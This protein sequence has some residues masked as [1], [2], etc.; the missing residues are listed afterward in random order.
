MKQT[1]QLKLSQH[2]T[3]TPQLQ[4][5]IRLLQLSTTELNQELEKF[6]TENPLLERE[7]AE[8]EPA[9]A[10]LNG[11]SVST[12]QAPA[13]ES[14]AENPSPAD[15]FSADIDWSGGSGPSVGSRDDAD[16]GDF[17]Q[18]PADSPSLRE[19]LLRQLSL[20]QL[21]QTDRNLVAFLIEALNDDGYL[22]QPLEAGAPPARGAADP[23]RA[24]DRAQ[25]PAELRPDG[26]GARSCAEHLSFSCC[27]ANDRGRGTACR[28]RAPRAAAPRFR[29]LAKLH[30]EDGCGRRQHPRAHRV[31]ARNQRRDALIV[32]TPPLS[33]K[34][35][36]CSRCR[37][38]RINRMY[39]EIEQPEPVR[40][41]SPLQAR[42]LI[43]NVNSDLRRSCVSQAM[44]IASG[45]SSSGEVAI[46]R[47]LARDRRH[48]Q[49]AVDGL[50]RHDPEVHVYASRNI[51]TQVFLRKPRRDGNWRRLFRNRHPRAAQA[52]GG[53][54]GRPE[55]SLGQQDLRY[56]QPTGNRGRAPHHRQVP[57]IPAD[58]LGQHEK[59]PL[60]RSRAE[61]KLPQIWV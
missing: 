56:S 26:V 10:R 38:S 53:G 29:E 51:R 41:L 61:S 32:P 19:H 4:Q 8:T 16:D 55:A 17:P 14:A 45:T 22:T 48:P 35:V 9:H 28:E 20:T 33:G 6:L 59:G 42:W 37:R 12:V 13:E 34:G 31:S 5:S 3:L 57:R 39:A 43:K 44:S 25:A 46:V 52:A 36:R 23:R 2:L 24:A 11:E 40:Q 50:A 30:A 15:V 58:S 54:G 47:C 49:L 1:L 27:V 21:E 7:D 60:R 18:V